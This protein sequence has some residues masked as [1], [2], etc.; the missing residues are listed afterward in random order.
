M[1]IVRWIR[2]HSLSIVFFALFLGAIAVQSLTGLSSYNSKLTDHQMPTIGYLQYLQTGDFLDGTF[3]NW[4]AAILQLGLLIVFG[5]K[6]RQ[7]GAAHSRKPDGESHKNRQPKNKDGA[8]R[9]WIYRN[10]LSLAFALL[11]LGCFAAH[12][13][14]GHMAYNENQQMIA[15]RPVSAADYLL[16]PAFW[17][18]CTQTWEAEFAVMGIFIILT[19]FLRQEGSPESKPVNTPD[20]DTGDT[21]K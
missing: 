11:F 16:M 3:S 10:S 14:F 12:L 18:S 5:E 17:F 6:L 7:K 8:N 4:Q 2:D 20:S 15:L 1:R 19:V 13:V 21:N 9:S